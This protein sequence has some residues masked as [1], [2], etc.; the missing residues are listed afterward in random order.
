MRHLIGGRGALWGQEWAMA[1]AQKLTF[2]PLL[3]RYRIV[4]GLT[5]EALA[6]R[7][8]VSARG[9]SDMERGLR[10][11]P[12]QDTISRL[13]QALDLSS[14]ERA[15]FEAASH[16]RRPPRAQRIPG[17]LVEKPAPLSQTSG[18]PIGAFL[19]ATPASPLVG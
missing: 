18:L 10:R 8:G 4:A 3:K 19:G 14:D 6:E 15:Q 9:I 2:G 11:A 16:Q 13:A 7:A 17:V 12:Y 1:S 5:Q